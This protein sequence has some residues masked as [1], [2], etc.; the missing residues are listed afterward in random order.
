MKLLASVVGLA[1]LV[2]EQVAGLTPPDVASSVAPCPGVVTRKEVRSLSPDEWNAYNSAVQSAYNDRWIDWFGFLHER[3]AS[4]I[5]S[6]AVF[7]V[8]HRALTRDYEKILQ[9]YN[10]AVAV[11]YWNMMV[12]YQNPAG[13]PVLSG[14]YFGGNG[15]ASSHCVTSGVA[16]SWQVTF[17]DV[18]CLRRVY[19]EADTIDTWYS[20]EF[21]T[22]VLQRSTKYADL[23]AGLEN[24]IHG[25]PHLSLGGDM[26]T[27]HSPLDPIFWLH[28]ANIDRL[29]AQWQAV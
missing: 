24:T 7:L 26:N 23:R 15:D 12:D 27:M 6:N 17:P 19:G 20:P 4:V 9:S 28:H 29:Y 25:L 2:A 5:H 10:P 1:L 14:S 13:S 21:I 8:Y 18:H 16:G 3:V 11:P 22:S